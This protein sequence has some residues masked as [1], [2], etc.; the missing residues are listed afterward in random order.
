M[1]VVPDVTHQVRGVGVGDFPFTVS[2]ECTIV[3]GDFGAAGAT[4]T[5]FCAPDEPDP[6][7][8]IEDLV[9]SVMALNA[10]KGII[11]SFDAKLGAAAGA[12]A[13]ANNN[14]DVAA[15]NTLNAFIN[16]VQAQVGN[17]ITSS[18]AADL[19]AQALGIIGVL[20]G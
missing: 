13:D 4:F 12:L 9:A 16:A 15:I 11:N 17:A 6:L 5:L 18:E 7:T 10:K 14:N 8:L 2:P 1:C 19:I 20:Q 3:P